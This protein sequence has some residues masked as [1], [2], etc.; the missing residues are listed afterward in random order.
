MT[1][2][3]MANYS[4]DDLSFFFFLVGCFQVENDLQ[5]GQEEADYLG[6]HLVFI[7]MLL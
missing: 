5:P 2:N 6:P 4:Q 3:S 1:R 7:E